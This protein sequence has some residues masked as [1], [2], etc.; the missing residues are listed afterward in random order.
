[1]TKL[2]VLI[3]GAGLGGLAAAI[4]L[5][6][7][8]HSVRVLEQ[9]A[10]LGEVGAG[11][12]I[13]PN[14][15]RI[16]REWGLAKKFE[17]KAIKP[18]NI[19]LRAY[20]SG[21]VLS[22]QPL[23]PEFSKLYGAPYWHIHRA[24]FHQILVEAAQEIG[25]EI[26]LGHRVE[27]IE[28]PEQ[29]RVLVKALTQ[30]NSVNVAADLV[31]GADGIKSRTRSLFLGRDDLAYN[32][33]DLAYRMLIRTENLAKN[34]NLKFLLKPNLNFWMG[35]GMHCV[36]YLLHEYCNIVVLS[37]DT[38]PENVNI[39]E[40]TVQ[41][42]RDLFSGWDP[43]F[44]ELVSLVESTS[45]WRL[46]NSRELTAWVHPTQN[47]ALLGDACHAT[48]PYLAQGAAQAVEDG[49]VLGEILGRLE[50]KNQIHDLLVI[51]ERLRKSRTT[52]VVLNSTELGMKT[53]H[54]PDGPERE[55]RDKLLA[56]QPPQ[57]GCPNK[58][59]D[60]IFQ[61]FLY[62]YNAFEEV[63]KAWNT[64]KAGYTVEPV[65]FRL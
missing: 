21:D 64:Y 2:E 36:V 60:P 4:G 29:N 35:P 8:G 57:V 49:C 44:Q 28:Y 17:K 56:I 3:V 43:K 9:A 51:Y 30:G 10:E 32:T 41:E 14:S 1:M 37:P 45:K 13:P 38:L 63:D 26:A 42:L 55:V 47:F 61:K 33:G 40:A 24:H 62:G 25:V 16:F 20:D 18:A 52:Q 19:F 65:T 39:Q 53:F 5:R 15:S 59:A 11:I 7:A 58:F 48:L 23:D 22:T 12:Q 6:R 46:Q 27:N 50:N 31:I 34:D 54:L